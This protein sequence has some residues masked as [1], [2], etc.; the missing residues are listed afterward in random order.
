LNF[1]GRGCKTAKSMSCLSV[2]KEHLD[3]HWKDFHEIWYLKIFGKSVEKI[4]V[5]LK[6]DWNNGYY[7]WRLVNIYN[8]TSLDSSQNKKC[9]I[10]NWQRNSKHILYIQY[11]FF[12]EN[13]PVNDTM[14]KYVVQPDRPQMTI[15]AEMMWYECRTKTR[16]QTHTRY[17]I[18]DFLRQ[19][20]LCE[21]ASMLRYTYIFCLVNRVK[22]FERGV[23]TCTPQMHK[24]SFGGS[25]HKQ[26]VSKGADTF[27]IL[28]SLKVMIQVT[29]ELHQNNQKALEMRCR[30]TYV[31]HPRTICHMISFTT[32][33]PPIRN[34]RKFDTAFAALPV[35]EPQF[36][37]KIS[38]TA[39]H[40]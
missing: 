13:H 22:D 30:Y 25:R 17:V 20:W 8:N 38:Y 16:I 34:K 32:V 31:L 39:R 29:T 18:L 26:R 3:S 2:R 33:I 21:K 10:Q 7:T 14:W 24:E 11:V 23:I 40:R 27:Y 9:C 6:F 37:S 12:F 4:N 15:F 28:L 1:I 19:K 36:S 35:Q 5:S